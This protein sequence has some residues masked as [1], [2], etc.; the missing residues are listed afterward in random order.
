MCIG[1][2]GRIHKFPEADNL[3]ALDRYSMHKFGIIFFIRG[4]NSPF[5]I[6]QN[7]DFVV[8]C[9]KFR[10]L[11]TKLSLASPSRVK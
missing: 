2:H 1:S 6:P 3:S 7:N 8:F 4:F 9:N 5:G 10:R 11:W